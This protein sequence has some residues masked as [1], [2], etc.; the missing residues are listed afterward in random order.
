WCR[1]NPLVATLASASALLLVLGTTLSTYF[2]IDATLAKNRAD[3]EALKAEA[4]A[5]EAVMHAQREGEQ[6]TNAIPTKDSPDREANAA[7]ANLYVLRMNTVQVALENGN[8]PLARDLLEQLRQ[9]GPAT[10][11][12]PG[13]E[14]HYHWRFCHNDQRT[15]TGH[16]GPIA[17]VAFSADGTRLASSAHD[18]T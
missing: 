2:A 3:A 14:W 18:G 9:P 4:K 17:C 10:N 15:L 13:W 16:T 7:R 6:R 12:S 8:V 5:R 1:R 11:E